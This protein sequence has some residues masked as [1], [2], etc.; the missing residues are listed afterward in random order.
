MKD[1]GKQEV[2]WLAHHTIGDRK[3]GAVFSVGKQGPTRYT[4]PDKE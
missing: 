4:A 1:S 2:A 3:C